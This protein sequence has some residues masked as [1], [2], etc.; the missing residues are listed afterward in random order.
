[1]TEMRR[2]LEYNRLRSAWAEEKSFE[3]VVS[4]MCI[5]HPLGDIDEVDGCANLEL[6]EEFRLQVNFLFMWRRKWKHTPVFLPGESHGHRS[7]MGFCS[8]GHKES[9]STD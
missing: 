5:S 3:Y 1:M 6:R 8:W 9:Y 4:E 7:P 2:T